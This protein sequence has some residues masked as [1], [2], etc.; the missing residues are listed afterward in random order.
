MIVLVCGRIKEGKTSRALY[1]ARVWTPGVVVW[2]P[3][4][5]ITAADLP[6]IYGEQNQITYVQSGD[7]LED[8]IQ[9]RAFDN[10]PIVFLPDGLQL[11]EA[12]VEMCEVLFNPPERFNNFAL[13]VDE[14]ADLQSAHRI[15]PHLQR[16]VKQHPRSV[17]IIQTTHSLQDWHRS[18]RDLTSEVHTFRLRGRS[19]EALVD[20]CDG[21]QELYDKIARLPRHHSVRIN[22]E[23]EDGQMEVEDVGPEWFG[24][25]PTE[26][27]EE[28][29]DGE[30]GREAGKTEEATA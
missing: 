6:A 2:D 28:E 13:I 30:E 7:E 16:A 26:E 20:F 23:A 10:G 11:E 17:L 25:A 3:R 15:A 14:A 21:D 27:Q 22:F 12:F 29:P 8:A 24:R 19:L 1:L 9:D 5:R 18:S 4:H